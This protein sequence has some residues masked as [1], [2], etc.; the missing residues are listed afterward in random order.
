MPKEFIKKYIYLLALHKMN[1]FHWHLT[2]DQGWR[3]EIK[4]YPKLTEIG[5]WRKGTITGH[6][7]APT[8]FD[9]TPHGGFYTQED[10]KEIV[11]YAKKHFV[12][13]VPEIEMPGHAQAALAAYPEFGNYPDSPVEVWTSFGV[14]EHIFCPR[15]ETISFLQDILEEVMALFPHSKWIHIG[16]DE[17]KKTQW[18]S[19]NFVQNKISQLGLKNENELQSYFISKIG[20]FIISKGRSFIGWDEILEGGLAEGAAVMSWRGEKG[21]IAAASMGHY[22]VMAPNS[23]LYFDWPQT[24]SKFEPM[25]ITKK[26]CTLSKVY[27]YEPIPKRLNNK[28]QSKYILGAQGQVWT[29]YMPNPKHVEYMTFPRACALSEL[30]WSPVERKNFAH[31]QNKLKHH[32]HFLDVLDVNYHPYVFP[33]PFK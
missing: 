10:I 7:R 3:I 33:W 28:E 2:E 20:E 13:I 1:I 27:N 6:A 5:A 14:S 17:A 21:G 26:A 30:L 19:S 8:G 29:E 15:E 12:Q 31:F 25:G 9:G 4:K 32:F 11:G 18:K 16:G 23:H 22:T 24:Q